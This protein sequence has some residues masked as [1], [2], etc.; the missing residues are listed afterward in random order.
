VP[1]RHLVLLLPGESELA[2]LSRVLP[3]EDLRV[4]GIVEPRGETTAATIARILE[5]PVAM[6]LQELDPPPGT[7]CIVPEQWRDDAAAALLATAS[8]C[9]VTTADAFL[10]TELAGGEEQSPRPRSHVDGFPL[11]VEALI[12]ELAAATGA[13]SASVMLLQPRLGVLLVAGAVGVPDRIVQ[14]T[15]L[16]LGQGLAGRA[17]ATGSVLRVTGPHPGGRNDPALA[18]AICHPIRRQERVVGVVNLAR[19]EG[20]PAWRLDPVAAVAEREVALAEALAAVAGQTHLPGLSLDLLRDEMRELRR[21]TGDVAE[22]L[23]AWAGLLA[24]AAGCEQAAFA[25]QGDTQLLVAEGDAD[26]RIRAVQLP[27]EGSGWEDPLAGK[28]CSTFHADEDGR[29]TL[30]YLPLDPDGRRAAVAL[31]FADPASAHRFRLG[32]EPLL[33]LLEDQLALL[34]ATSPRPIVPPAPPAGDARTTERPETAAPD[35]GERPDEAGAE[36]LPPG[37]LAARLQREL[38]RCRRYHVGCGVIALQAGPAADALAPLLAATLRSTDLLAVW[39]DGRIVVVTPEEGQQT[40][41]VARRLAA[42]IRERLG[43]PETPRNARAVHPGRFADAS[44]LLQHVL[45]ATDPEV[46]PQG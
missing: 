44:A 36:I 5:L 6:T 22:T 7:V 12:A 33:T 10:A 41:R 42:V 26:G 27:P 19:H 2:L 40:D 18:E 37:E 24:V 1:T 28:P 9:A 38:D 4:L 15:C 16:P 14:R 30:V 45:S 43:L 17:A 39:P 34:L 23:A 32:A 46:G 20:D 11:E 25:I 13:G 35:D 29:L 8:G 21:A 31:T 3:R